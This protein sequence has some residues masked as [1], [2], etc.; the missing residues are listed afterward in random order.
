ME[1]EVESSGRMF[2]SSYITSLPVSN[3]LRSTDVQM[4]ARTHV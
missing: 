3:V 1:C 4:H 2:V